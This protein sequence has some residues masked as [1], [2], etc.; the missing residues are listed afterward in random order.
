METILRQRLREHK[1]K[2]KL[3]DFDISI[4]ADVSQDTVR[5]FLIGEGKFMPRTIH[6]LQ[7]YIMN[8]LTKEQKVETVKHDAEMMVLENE[9]YKK[10]IKEILFEA[11]TILSTDFVFSRAIFNIKK[12]CSEVLK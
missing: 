12:I 5:R 9:K 3:S 10:A 8:F 2:Y 7:K 1:K 4:D 11:N 6:K